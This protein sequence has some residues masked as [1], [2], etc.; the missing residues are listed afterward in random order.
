MVIFRKAIKAEHL[1]V[2]VTCTQVA[3]ASMQLDKENGAIS[4]YFTSLSWGIPCPLI[5]KFHP[6]LQ[7]D[8]GRVEREPAS[9]NRNLRIYLWGLPRANC[10]EDGSCQDFS[11]DAGLPIDKA[12][13]Q[14]TYKYCLINRRIRRIL[15]CFL[16]FSNHLYYEL[17][18]RT[19][20]YY[21]YYYYF[22]LLMRK[23]ACPKSHRASQILT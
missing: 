21:Y 11:R 19:T 8:S 16:V 15:Y 5:W 12:P 14:H 2:R 10:L 1:Y 13:S 17:K 6:H 7:V 18:I 4:S 20:Y 9:Q 3:A 22:I 23:Q